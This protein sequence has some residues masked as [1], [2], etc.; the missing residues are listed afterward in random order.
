MPLTRFG[1]V[2]STRMFPLSH[3]GRWGFSADFLRLCSTLN[4]PLPLWEREADTCVHSF[5]S[6]AGEGS[7]VL[8]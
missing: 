2:A 7:L 8:R 3:E 5:C 6:G 4:S 1:A